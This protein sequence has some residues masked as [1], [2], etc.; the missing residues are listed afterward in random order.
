MAIQA[1][2]AAARIAEGIRVYRSDIGH[3]QSRHERVDPL[4]EVRRPSLFPEPECK[5]VAQ[6]LIESA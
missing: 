2:L 5:P 1:I 3:R 4:N 6:Y